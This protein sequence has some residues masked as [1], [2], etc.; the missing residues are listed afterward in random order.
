MAQS[1]TITK[2]LRQNGRV[3]IRFGKREYEF[4]S[5]QAVQEFVAQKLNTEVL[6]A[7]AIAIVVARQ[8]TLANLALVEGKTL[9][10][11]PTVNNWGTVS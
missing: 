10:V 7:L 6:E 11:D 4:A 9:T 5:Q 1:V 3:Y 8:P 2:V